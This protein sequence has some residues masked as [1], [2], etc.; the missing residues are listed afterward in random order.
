[1]GGQRRRLPTAKGGNKEEVGNALA[2][3][4]GLLSLARTCPATALE[5]LGCASVSLH[6]AACSVPQE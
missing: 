3:D 4:S 5:C 1:M 2:D 6:G